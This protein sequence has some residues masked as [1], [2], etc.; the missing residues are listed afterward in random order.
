[1][2]KVFAPMMSLDASGTLG[3]AVTFS[4]WKGRNYVRERV[5][6]SNPK[7]EGQTGRRAMFRWL[8]QNWAALG[9]ADK[10]TWQDLADQIIASPFNAFVKWNMETWHN[11]LA[12]FKTPDDLRSNTPSDRALSAAAWEENRI[13]LSST[14]TTANAQWGIIY[15]AS[16]TTPVVESVGKA[17][18]VELD[19][20][21]LARDTFW[22]PPT[23]DTWY[24]DSIAFSDDG[25]KAAAGGEQTAAPP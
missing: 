15:F 23:V 16:L 3:N 25:K 8:T 9:S 18:I 24:F 6:P 1:M 13:K 19:E 14:A 7:S 21:I 11:Y 5:I 20:D 4:K 2:V 12:P 22:T 17:I 10:A